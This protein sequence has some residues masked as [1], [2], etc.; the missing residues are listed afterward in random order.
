MWMLQIARQSVHPY[1]GVDRLRQ[2]E[3]NGLG[4][5]VSCF[6][7]ARVCPMQLSPVSEIH[8]LRR[9]LAGRTVRR[10]FTRLLGGT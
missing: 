6:E 7:C 10:M 4:E 9:D 1:D 8:K 3:Q 2:A 5:C